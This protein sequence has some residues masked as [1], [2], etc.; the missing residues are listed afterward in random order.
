M[1]K[2]KKKAAHLLL[3]GRQ[4]PCDGKKGGRK[5]RNFQENHPD[6]CRGCEHEGAMSR[7]AKQRESRART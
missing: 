6:N 2:T 4:C 5:C 7:A 1:A 3:S